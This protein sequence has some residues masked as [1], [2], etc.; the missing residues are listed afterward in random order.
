MLT[1]RTPLVVMKNLL[2]LLLTLSCCSSLFAQ[3]SQEPKQFNGKEII[4]YYPSWQVYDR[5][6][7]M[8]PDKLNYRKVS[9][10]IYAFFRPD[11]QGGIHGLDAFADELV[12]KG[13]RDWRAQ[14]DEAY[15]VP[16]TSLVK[17]AHAKKVKVLISI[18]GWEH[19]KYFSALASDSSSRVRFA[20]ECVGLVKT[21][22]IDGVDIDWEYPCFRGSVADKENFTLML[23]EIRKAFDAYNESLKPRRRKPLSLVISTSSAPEHARNIDWPNVLPLVDYVNVMTYDFSGSWSPKTS[24]KSPLY[25]TENQPESIDSSITYYT[26]VLKVPDSLMNIGVA[27]NGNAIVC[28]EGKVGL[29]EYHLRK[30]DKGSFP[31]D[32][33]QPTYYNIQSGLGQFSLH[34]DSTAQVPYALGLER[35]SFLSFENPQSINAKIDFIRQQNLHGMVIWDITGDAIETKAGSGY[36]RKTP[37]L[38]AVYEGMKEGE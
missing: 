17:L 10:I 14:G 19:S 2:S 4:A 20:E 16:G 6:K 37:L 26:E 32:Q 11:H 38:D 7:L 27:F 29:G 23:A 30:Y 34:Y 24:H 36:I 28:R 12:L 15:Y 3:K 8:T 21:Y 35:N 1:F 13:Q 5:E 9:T 22:D 25:S 31:A 18:G 33:G